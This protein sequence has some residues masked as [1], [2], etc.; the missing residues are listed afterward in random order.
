MTTLREERA[1][2][3]EQMKALSGLAASE[4]RDLTSDEYEK[5]GR[6]ESDLD[7]KSRHIERMETELEL[8]GKLTRA[9][10]A[11]H[12]PVAIE[13]D[14]RGVAKVSS[15]RAANLFARVHRSGD[16]AAID[17]LRH[18][19]GRVGIDTLAKR[20][21]AD[22]K[23][24]EARMLYAATDEYRDA[25]IAYIRATGTTDQMDAE[26][27]AALN[28]GTGTQGGYTVPVEFYRQ[29]VISERFY[30]IMRQLAR[31]IVT[32]DNGDVTVPK[33][34]DANRMSAGWVAEA[35]AFS[36][37]EDQFLKTT[38]QAFKAGTI[39]KVSDELILDSAFDIL[40]FVAESAGQAIGI[41]SNTAYV[42][43][44]SGSTT[45][46]EG[47]FTK[48]TVG[49]TMPTGNTSAVTYNGVVELLHSV[50][51][52]YRSRGVFVG[53][54]TVL[55]QLRQLTDSQNRPLWEPSVQ[56]GEPDSILGK[57]IY[58]DP[59]VAVPAANALSLGFGDVSRAYWIRDVQDITAKVLNELYAAN[60]QVGVRVHRRTDGDIVDTL[61]FKTLKQSAT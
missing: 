57:P 29:L 59:D 48:A 28:I 31:T 39:A 52:A 60:G 35:G 6:L 12:E 41:L 37:S 30:G 10:T 42:T 14:E 26:A 16:E 40:G 27:R 17:E 4:G 25:W 2:I 47:L 20:M 50:R 44:S 45:T 7:A 51:P 21:R 15:S 8:D 61:A 32:A 13:A 43:G 54:D 56:A 49:Y 22:K 19:A 24:H 58:A 9:H 11:A 23:D 38:L 36:E 55:K 46:P 3:W 33:V 18:M 5:Y 1:S 34:D 53:S